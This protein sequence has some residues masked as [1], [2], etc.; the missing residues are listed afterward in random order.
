[1]AQSVTATHHGALGPINEPRDLVRVRTGL[2]RLAGDHL[3]EPIHADPGMSIRLDPPE[4]RELSSLSKH[5][6]DRWADLVADRLRVGISFN[7]VADTL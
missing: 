2:E 3:F 1:L 5:G 4:V 6:S 7:D